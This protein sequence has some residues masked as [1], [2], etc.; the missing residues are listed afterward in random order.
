MEREFF[1]LFKLFYYID[2][3]TLSLISLD[4]FHFLYP[5]L[6]GSLEF[7]QVFLNNNYLVFINIFTTFCK[8]ELR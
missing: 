6:R 5:F 4:I 2:C 3:H 7:F 1:F 8:Y